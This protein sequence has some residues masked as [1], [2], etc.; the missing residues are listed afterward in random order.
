MGTSR[1]AAQSGEEVNFTVLPD[2]LQQPELAR[3]A[4]DYD[5]DTGHDDVLFLVVE[6]RLQARKGTLKVVNNLADRLTRH[7]HLLL[8]PRQVLH[9]GSD[10]YL[11]HDDL[12]VVR[13]PIFLPQGR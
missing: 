8:P 3:L 12:P 7:L 10:P 6:F 2:M 5:S 4:I 9:T 13:V 11:W 1:P